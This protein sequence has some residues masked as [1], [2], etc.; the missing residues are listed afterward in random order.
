M[1]MFSVIYV[2]NFHIF[3]VSIPKTRPQNFQSEWIFQN[4]L[5]SLKKFI[6]M[7]K[8]HGIPQD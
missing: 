1:G 3:E 7:S 2:S 5:V 6:H 4:S 8:I